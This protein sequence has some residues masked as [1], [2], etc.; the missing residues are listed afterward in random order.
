MYRGG[1]ISKLDV[2]YMENPRRLPFL[3]TEDV[4]ARPVLSVAEFASAIF[5]PME[6][7][8]LVNELIYPGAGGSQLQKE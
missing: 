3:A 8:F 2:Q 1:R 6:E 7:M 5:S 4:Q